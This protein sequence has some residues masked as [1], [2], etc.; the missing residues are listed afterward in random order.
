MI[1][2]FNWPILSFKMWLLKGGGALLS[3]S[4]LFVTNKNFYRFNQVFLPQSRKWNM[5]PSSCCFIWCMVN[6][7]I[8]PWVW[9]KLAKFSLHIFHVTLV[10]PASFRRWCLPWVNH[11]SLESW[12]FTPTQCNFPSK[13]I[14]SKCSYQQICDI[15]IRTHIIFS[16]SHSSLCSFLWPHN[17]HPYLQVGWG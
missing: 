10:F 3:R 15:S 7:T 6:L 13:M 17:F 16:E 9:E 8:E 5:D 1:F 12:E 2:L 4:D 11:D 14:T